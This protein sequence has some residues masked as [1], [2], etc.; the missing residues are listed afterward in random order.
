MIVVITD[1][2]YTDLKIIGDFIRPHNPQRAVSFVDELFSRC[3]ALSVESF[4]LCC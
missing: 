3:Q 2:A 1:A 4:M